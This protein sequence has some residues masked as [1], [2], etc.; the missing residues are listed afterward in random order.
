MT[1]WVVARAIRV[2]A[3]A[4]PVLHSEAPGPDGQPVP[5]DRTLIFPYAFR[6]SFAQRHANAS[7]PIDVLKKL[8]DHREAST[9]ASYYKVSLQRKRA[10]VK[11]MRLHVVDR[12][13]R[14]AP[15]DLGRRL[16]G[17]LGGGAVRQLYRTLQRQRQQ[18][19]LPDPVPVRGLGFFRPDPSY[20]AAIEDR[21]TTLKADRET[22][23]PW[24][25]TSS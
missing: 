9:T 3:D 8:M 24:T 11:T 17:P 16:R 12:S 1:A 25:P 22:A 13:G 5:F 15:D 18:Q 10:A 6:H 20:L 14:L 7:T 19:G 4:I 2:W 21:V 23:G